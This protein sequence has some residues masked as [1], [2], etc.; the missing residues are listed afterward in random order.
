MAQ[1]TLSVSPRTLSGRKV[2]KLRQEGKVPANIFGKK[3]PTTNIQVDA[4]EFLKVYKEVGESTL[5]YLGDRPVLVSEVTYHPVTDQLLHVSFR[6]VDLKAKVTAP[7]AVELTGEASAE[8]EKLGIM[9][10]QLDEVEIEALPTDMPEN[11]K[12][13]VS[14][15]SEVGSQITVVDLNLDSS[16]MTIKTDPTAIIVKIE[17]LA[18]EEKVEA[19]PT[20]E[21][22]AETPTT[23][24][25]PILETK[26]EAHE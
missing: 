4:K 24:P 25:A 12:V 17:A 20:T 2:K 26:A 23:E 19:P 14:S 6:Q 3:I 15:L 8:Q 16:K 10:Q 1:H 18:K 7:V 21:V 13:D 9:V 5:V 22:S 11:I